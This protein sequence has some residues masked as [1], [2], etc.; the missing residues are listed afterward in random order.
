MIESLKSAL[1][2]GRSEQKR[3]PCGA[4]VCIDYAHNAFSLAQLLRSLREYA[5][6]RLIVLFG[7]V[8]E[9]THLRRRDMGEVAAK[10]ADLAI[11]TSDN[12]GNESPEAIIADIAKGFDG[13]QTP[14]HAIPDRKTAILYALGLLQ[15]G[16]IL[17]LAGK[18][19]ETYQLIG[20]EKIPFCESDIVDEYIASQE[21]FDTA[22]AHL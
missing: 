12:P 20:Q 2:A 6:G 22:P 15:R 11:L 19:H 13:S 17:V 21:K 3:L 10:G 8:G 9:R 1:V 18:G 7:S 14:Y 4:C 16:D 5:T